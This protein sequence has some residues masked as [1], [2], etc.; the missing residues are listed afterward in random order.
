MPEELPIRIV[1]DSMS[2]NPHPRFITE[3]HWHRSI[4]ILYTN[5]S[6]GVV[7]ING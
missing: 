3:L 5:Q 7:Y 4:E 1:D 2:H 6:T